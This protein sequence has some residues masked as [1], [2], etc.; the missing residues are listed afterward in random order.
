MD[1]WLRWVIGGVILLIGETFV[2]TFDLLAI[3]IAALITGILTY[4]LGIDVS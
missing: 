1:F 3:G 4:V 2:G